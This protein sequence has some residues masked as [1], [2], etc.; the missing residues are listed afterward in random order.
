MTKR[1][2]E[3]SPP[4]STPSTPSC[5]NSEPDHSSPTAVDVP[6][7][8]SKY[9]HVSDHPSHST[10]AAMKCSL[11]PH[12]ETLAFSTFE[13][14]EIHYAKEHANRCSECRKNFPT[15]HFLELHIEENHDPLSDARRARGEKTYRCFVM[16]CDK[17]CSTP[18]K[19]RMHLIDKHMFPKNYDFFIVNSGIDKRS[20]MLRTRHRRPSSAA[21]RAL[22]REHQANGGSK[23]SMPAEKETK[24]AL[25][26]PAMPSI[27]TAIE[28]T[29]IRSGKA[30]G[31]Q[32][33]PS[34]VDMDSLSSTLNALKFVPPSVR[35]GRGGRK[36]GFSRS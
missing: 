3:D 16:D 30:S 32:E 31:A 8:L 10:A 12:H 6:V 18:Q 34:D 25:M 13:D 15:N 17:I 28:P 7:H 27:P 26:D 11:P 5:A 14:F 2:R 20:S 29:S 1:S 36:G 23:S 33:N 4:S 22:Y 9:L 24:E 21:S 19:R 35:F